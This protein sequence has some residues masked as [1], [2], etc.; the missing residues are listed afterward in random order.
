VRTTCPSNKLDF[1]LIRTYTILEKIGLRAYKLDL[2]PSV[3]I[4]PVFHLSLLEPTENRNQPIPGHIQPPP[5]P[6]IMD[7]EEEWEVEEILDSRYHRN[8]LQYRV[9]WTGFYDQDKMWYPASNFN[10]SPEVIAC[11]HESYPQKPAP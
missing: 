3:K 4:Y 10:N 1:K 11:F 2:P 6:V 9:K 8:H 5:P 7:N